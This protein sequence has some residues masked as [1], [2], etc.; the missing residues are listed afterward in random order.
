MKAVQVTEYHGPPVLVDVPDA[1]DRASARALTDRDVGYRTAPA[2]VAL[3]SRKRSSLTMASSPERR[4]QHHR[5]SQSRIS[6]HR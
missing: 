1:A 4:Q 3:R 2:L 6:T 5:R